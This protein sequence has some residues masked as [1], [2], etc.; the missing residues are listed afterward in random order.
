MGLRLYLDA[1]CTQEITDQNPD[2]SRK[3]VVA[4]ADWIDE[5]SL[6]IR[7]D[8]PTLTYENISI[9]AQDKPAHAIVQYAKDSNGIPGV[10]AESLALPN[11]SFEP[12]VRFWRKVT[13]PNV[14][15]AQEIATIKHS[16]KYDEYVR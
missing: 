2:H 3:P 16:R 1:A 5:R 15:D 7:S 9:T 13:V 10:Y 6:W 12:A 14:N 11:S 4:G 8:D